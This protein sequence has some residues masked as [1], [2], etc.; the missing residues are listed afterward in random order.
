VS[1]AAELESLKSKLEAEM[2]TAKGSMVQAAQIAR[3]QVSEIQ[4]ALDRQKARVLE[5]SQQRGTLAVLTREVESARSAYDSSMQRHT[6]VRL[7]SRLD[8]TDIAVLNA[9]IPPLVP[10]F[11]KIP[12]NIVLSVFSGW[13]LGAG[14]ALRLEMMNRRVRSRDDLAYAAGVP[15]LAEIARVSTRKDKR[16]AAKAAALKAKNTNATARPRAA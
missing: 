3:R 10:A 1:A 12:L 13:M 16:E 5:L 14:A 11:P 6:Q 7:E 4:Q 8:Q 9:A 2:N 15:V